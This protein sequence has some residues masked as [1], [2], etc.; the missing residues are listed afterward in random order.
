MLNMAAVSTSLTDKYGVG[1]DCGL[2]QKESGF[3][4][5]I[6][7]SDLPKNNGFTIETIVGWRSVKSEL[8]L[9]SFAKSVVVAMNKASPQQQ[10]VFQALAKN[11]IASRYDLVFQVNSANVDC[12]SDS[13]WKQQWNTVYI[14]IESGYLEIDHD[15]PQSLTL[16]VIEW[17]SRLL[18]MVLALLPVQQV[19]EGEEEG[20]YTRIEVNKYERSRI[21][22]AACIEIQ[23]SK[24]K[25]CGFDFC[26]HYGE[27]GDG[28]IEVHHIE[29]VS[30]IQPGTIVDPS[31]DLVPL[32]SNCHSMIHRRI[33]PYS[34][35]ELRTI[36]SGATRN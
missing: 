15:D 36:I 10:S 21:N 5:A 12:P 6:R 16:L 19:A 23:G 3:V 11:H 7:P 18:G 28:F 34:I 1:L 8:K 27:I 31:V 33:P 9:D 26:E 17:S 30:G 14:S 35:E 13:I 25:G 4:V 24:C 2:E 32:C 29:P 22:R 20:G